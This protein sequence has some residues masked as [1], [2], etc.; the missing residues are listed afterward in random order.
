MTRPPDPAQDTLVDDNQSF[1]ETP[2]GI[3][4]GAGGPM[5]QPGTGIETASSPAGHPGAPGADVVE[6]LEMSGGASAPQMGMPSETPSPQADVP[7][8]LKPLGDQGQG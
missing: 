2:A 1:T 3:D 4:M 8:S 6:G 7:D 5:S